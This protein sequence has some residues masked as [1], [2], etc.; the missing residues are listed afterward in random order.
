MVSLLWWILDKAAW[1]AR[2]STQSLGRT[3]ES[4]HGRPSHPGSLFVALLLLEKAQQAASAHSEGWSPVSL[5]EPRSYRP[6]HR[7]DAAAL[8]PDR[9]SCSE[10]ESIMDMLRSLSSINSYVAQRFSHF[11]LLQKS[12]NEV[13]VNSVTVW[14]NFLLYV[15]NFHWGTRWGH[16]EASDISPT[17]HVFLVSNCKGCDCSGQRACL[18]GMHCE[19]KKNSAHTNLCKI[20]NCIGLVS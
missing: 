13:K 7:F 19:Y 15:S 10:S 8:T 3:I 2:N 12:W 11:R 6:A 9:T 5:P 20:S 16:T 14:L 1:L 4:V 17:F 18:L